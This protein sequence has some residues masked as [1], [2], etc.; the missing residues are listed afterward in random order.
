MTQVDTTS[1]VTKPDP[2]DTDV[3]PASWI[4]NGTFTMTNRE[5]GEHRTFQIRTQ[6]DDAKFAPGKRV[7]AL[8]R[9]PDNESDYQPFGFVSED[10]TI[11]VWRSKQGDLR[12]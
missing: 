11:Y 2:N 7:I 10:G 1:K 12:H 9:G 5:S 3:A 8:L 6:P 4:L